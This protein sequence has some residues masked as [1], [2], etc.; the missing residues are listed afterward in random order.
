MQTFQFRRNLWS[1][2]AAI[3]MGATVLLLIPS[4]IEFSGAIKTSAF[5]PTYVPIL[6]S[7][8]MIVLG[9]LLI[10]K[11]LV[12][13]KDN[14]VKI[15]IK[16]ELHALLYFVLVVA[17]VLIMPRIGFLPSSIIFCSLALGFMRVKK[18]S[19]YIITNIVVTALWCTFKYL[20]YVRLP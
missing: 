1:G 11:S 8:L 14:Y 4:Q 2:S 3:I 13:K 15:K 16:E 10:G 12:L 18:V 20:L 5:P 17:Y 6:M 19:H 7:V 9:V